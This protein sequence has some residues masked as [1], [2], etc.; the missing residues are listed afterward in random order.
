[1]V[2]MFFLETQCNCSLGLGLT[3][4]KFQWKIC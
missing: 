1:M 4:Q 2:G 3:V